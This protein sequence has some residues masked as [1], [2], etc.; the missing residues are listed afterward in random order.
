MSL[1]NIVLVH[2]SYK[3]LDL[4]TI[5]SVLDNQDNKIYFVLVN[6]PFAFTKK[7]IIFISPHM[8]IF[9]YGE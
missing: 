7:D 5:E 3:G 4:S 6:F 1:Y 2:N 8:V 9:I